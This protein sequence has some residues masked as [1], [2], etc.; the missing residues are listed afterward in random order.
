VKQSIIKISIATAAVLSPCWLSAAQEGAKAYNLDAIGI[1][2]AQEN[3]AYLFMKWQDIAAPANEK[4]FGQKSVKTFGKQTNIN[5]LKVLDMSP[6]VNYTSND[7]IGVNSQTIRIRG[8][9]D[10]G[11][12][13]T[14]NIEEIPIT[15]QPGGGHTMFDMENISQIDL[16]K[17]Y[18][19]VD[20][21]LGFSNLIGKANLTVKRPSKE[22]GAE[23]SQSMGSNNLSRSFIRVDSGEKGNVSAFGSFSVM[24]SDKNKGEGK[25]DTNSAMIGVVYK[26]TPEL[27]S[28]LF[29]AYNKEDYNNYA[30]LTY[31]EAKNLDKYY[32][33]DFGTDK[34]KSTY[35]DYNKEGYEDIAI[36]ANLEYKISPDSKISFKPYF[37]NDEGDYWYASGANVI[38]WNRDHHLFGAILRYEKSF[39]EALNA[40]I[41]YWAH[42]QLPPGPP[43]TQQRYTVGANGLIYAGW[44][45]LNKNGYHEFNSPFA[46]LSGVSGKLT[47]SAG[48]RYLNMRI[49]DFKS[50][51]FNTNASTSSDYNTALQNTA[52]DPWATAGAQYIR[53]WLPSLYIG[54]NHS[55]DATVY[56]DYART[57]GSDINLQPTYA[58]SRATFVAKGIRLQSLVDARDVELSDNFDLGVKYKAGDIYLNPNLYA[59]FVKNKQGTVY[60]PALGVSYPWNVADALAYGAELEASGAI[61]SDLD[62]LLAL[63]YNKFQYTQDLRTSATA[64]KATKG[65][66]VPN[67]PEYMAKAALTY[68]IMGVNITP[69]VKYISARYGDILNNE[70]IDG[71]AT[72]DL[73]I[74]YEKKGF[75]GAKAAEFRLTATNLF[76]KK[77]I[78]Q[79]SASDDTLAPTYYTGAPFGI[80]ANVNFKF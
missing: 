49:G 33:K 78:S 74:S 4:S 16:Y 65:N 5:P 22:F 26:P 43:V 6:S 40:K 17:G 9:S 62:F 46:E 19:P 11:P 59:A 44:V 3:E 55:K 37:L 63:S 69:T 68:K 53:E 32:S 75:F 27:K 47:Y 71:Y 45:Q 14:R 67:A 18:I 12:V 23:L 36:M 25:I 1:S 15:G 79:I 50:Y 30:S 21:G 29:F 35:Y 28:E 20:K 58:G 52:V 54:Y 10:G 61:R 73:D 34:T 70:K 41:G 42:R 24:S 39:S 7:D 56:F 38:K 13:S 51:T 8:R 48:I 60:D 57:Y 77:Y 80:Y 64:I 31:A 2:G 72:A 76:D 66:Q